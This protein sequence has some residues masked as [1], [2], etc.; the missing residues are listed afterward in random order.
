MGKDKAK[1]VGDYGLQAKVLR[2]LAKYYGEVNA[3]GEK[4]SPILQRSAVQN[5]G[6]RLFFEQ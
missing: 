3:A 1:P 5:R 6:G 4:E 2:K